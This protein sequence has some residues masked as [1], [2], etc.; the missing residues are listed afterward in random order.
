MAR[1]TETDAACA[2]RLFQD[3]LA[4]AFAIQSI[5]KNVKLFLYTKDSVSLSLEVITNIICNVLSLSTS[6]LQLI[7]VNHPIFQPFY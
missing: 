4:C 1:L 6:N 2:Y 5:K 7:F 3:S